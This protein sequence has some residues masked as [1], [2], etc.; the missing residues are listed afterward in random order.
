MPVPVFGRSGAV[1]NTKDMEQILA[2]KLYSHLADQ[3]PDLLLRLQ[4]KQS[5][6]AYIKNKVAS[7]TALSEELFEASYPGHIVEEQC[8]QRLIEDIGPSRFHYISSVLEEDF[9]E[10]FN[11]LKE[12]GVLTYEICNLIDHCQEDFTRFE[13]NYE[14]EDNRML[15]YAVMGTI[16]EYV[17]GDRPPVK[18]N[19]NGL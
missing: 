16:S 17:G 1:L 10:T 2:E 15:R 13:F 12:S 18:E 3:H 6:T 19:N 5:V 7:V 9:E 14:N 8:L 4:D 11:Q